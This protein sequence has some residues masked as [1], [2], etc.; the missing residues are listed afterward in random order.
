VSE[1]TVSNDPPYAP[2]LMPGPTGTASGSGGTGSASSSLGAAKKPFFLVVPPDDE[3][4]PFAL[5]A[6]ATRR[7][8]LVADAD[9]AF[10]D[11]GFILGVDVVG[12]GTDAPS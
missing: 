12:E 5:G 3:K 10:G 8:N 1:L 2:L 7:R 9:I 6:L 4:R 11:N